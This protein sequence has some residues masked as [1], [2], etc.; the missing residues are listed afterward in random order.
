MDPLKDLPMGF[1]MALLRNEK[2]LSNFNNMTPEKRQEI[3]DKTHAVSSKAEME[4]LVNGI[5]SM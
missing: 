5:A 1:G 2:A 3:I 4:S